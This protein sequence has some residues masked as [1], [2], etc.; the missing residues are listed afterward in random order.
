MSDRPGDA[1]DD[2]MERL[3]NAT[4]AAHAAF[5]DADAALTLSLQAQ[6]VATEEKG[7]L[8]DS[9]QALETLL[10]QQ[11][12]EMRALRTEIRALHARFERGTDA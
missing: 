4:R 9:I 2:A 7:S 1:F 6:R 11:G 8:R 3:H 10:M 12:D 5:E